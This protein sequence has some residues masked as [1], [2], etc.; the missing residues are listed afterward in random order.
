MKEEAVSRSKHV[1][2]LRHSIK[3][4][5]FKERF[6]LQKEA[7]ERSLGL[8]SADEKPMPSFTFSTVSCRNVNFFSNRP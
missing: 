8:M 7:N 1:S 6:G 5:S 2:S 3:L 4:L